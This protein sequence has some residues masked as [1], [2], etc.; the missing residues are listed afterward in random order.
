MPKHLRL[1]NEVPSHSELPENLE[2]RQQWSTRLAAKR[3]LGAYTCGVASYGKGLRNNGSHMIN[4]LVQLFD[5]IPE[6]T[7]VSRI[8]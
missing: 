8:V 7:S 6:I 5:G 2:Y 4:L 1:K 3:N